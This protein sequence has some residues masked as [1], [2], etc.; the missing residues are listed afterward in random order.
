M[1]EGVLRGHAVHR[2]AE[3]VAQA[4]VGVGV[5]DAVLVFGDAAG[6]DI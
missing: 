6:I 3:P 4:V 5:A 2:L 1:L